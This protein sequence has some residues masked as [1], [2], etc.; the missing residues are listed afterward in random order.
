MS[1]PS[2][3]GNVMIT[4]ARAAGRSLARD[5]YEIEH[6]QVSD[7]IPEEFVSRANLRAE[8]IAQVQLSKGRPGYGFVMKEQGVIDGTDKTNRFIVDTLSGTLNFLHAHPHFAVSIALEREGKL[9]TGVIFD[10]IRNELFWAE[11]GRGAWIDRKKLCV[12]GRKDL[13]VATLATVFA[14]K[15]SVE[16]LSKTHWNELACV[17]PACGNLRLSGSVSLDLAYIAAGRIDGFWGAGVHTCDIAAGNV[18]IE[19]AGGLLSYTVNES[20]LTNTSLRASNEYLLSL[21]ESRL[22]FA[23][24]LTMNSGR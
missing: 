23:L 2:P 14:P 6:L 11:R 24:S 21:L 3:V 12:S 18:L 4:A 20:P 16:P 5:F 19:E 1:V 10:V 13:K 7:K 9:L 17:L 8:N 15:G 22:S